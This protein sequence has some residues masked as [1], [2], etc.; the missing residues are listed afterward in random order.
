M[1]ARAGQRA[2]ARLLI[3]LAASVAAIALGCSEGSELEGQWQCG[4]LPVSIYEDGVAS[5]Y[6][7]RASW[8]AI[9]NDAIRLE[10][11]ENSQAKV[12]ELRISGKAEAG[13][14][15]AVLGFGGV[16][17]NCAKPLPTQK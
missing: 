1:I 8:A 5:L 16:R 10:Y 17:V 2:G 15:I 7:E 6:G 3:W 11:Q 4:G 9:G 13:Q 14:R 12:A